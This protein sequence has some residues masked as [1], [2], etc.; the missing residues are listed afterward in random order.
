MSA[1]SEGLGTD[2]TKLKVLDLGTQVAGPFAATILGDFGAE[3]IKCEQPGAGDPSR[4]GG[5]MGT[6]WLVNGRNKRSVTLNLRVPAGQALLKRLASWADVLVENFRPGTMGRWGLGYEDLQAV[7]PRLVYVSV[8]GFGQSGPLAPLSG[9]DY[10]GS[11]Y[12]GLTAVTGYPD[13]PPVLPGL[14]II[15]YMSGLFAAVGA[16]EAIRRRDAAGPAGRGSYVDQAL[17][18]TAMRIA[19]M[20]I[21]AYSLDGTVRE[22]IGGMPVVEGRTESGT[23]YVYRTRDD[24]WLS[25]HCVNDQQF[26]E[27]RALVGA[28][29]LD[30][31]RFDTY[32]SRCQHASD[33]YRIISAW[34]AGYDLAELWP[35]VAR[36]KIPA[37]PVNTVADLFSDAHVRARGMLVET[38]VNG[39]PMAM[40]GVVPHLEPDPG[41]V[42]WAGPAL[43]SSNRE[44]YAGLL[45]LDDQELARLEQDGVI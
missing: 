20:D 34:V 5:P 26:A 11:A 21:A 23:W 16:L 14:F 18:E 2:P 22:R 13:R 28:S 43:G 1:P 10:T 31:H 29:E 8:S 25:L 42:R 44:V 40:P 19:A 4:T 36:T 45:G 3:V 33:L 15:D 32:P 41:E 27:L 35:L 6:V 7:N 38:E 39:R 30:E 37:G 17:Y 12:G 24:R 9:Y